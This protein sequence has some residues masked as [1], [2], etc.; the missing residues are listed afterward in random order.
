MNSRRCAA[1]ALCLLAFSGCHEDPTVVSVVVQPDVQA[2]GLF[3]DG[4]QASS[5]AGTDGTGGAGGS[6]SI[7]ASGLVSLGSSSF[8]P[9]APVTPAVPS[10]TTPP[11]A[12]GLGDTTQAGSMLISGTITTANAQFVTYK[13]TGGDIVVSGALLSGNTGATAPANTQTSI[14]LEAKNGTSMTCVIAP[15]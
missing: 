8:V 3:A 9:V 6:L 15:K 11:L 7:T 2:L 14:T 1:V 4:G 12:N 5:G 10:I 13:S